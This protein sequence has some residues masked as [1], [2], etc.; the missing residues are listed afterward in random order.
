MNL[1][2]LTA[3]SSEKRTQ[4][5]SIFYSLAMTM[6]SSCRHKELRVEYTEYTVQN[7]KEGQMDETPPV[8]EVPHLMTGL[9][10]LAVVSNALYF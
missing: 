3:E 4:V 10:L 2:L 6:G 1:C 8:I 7:R 5:F 9:L